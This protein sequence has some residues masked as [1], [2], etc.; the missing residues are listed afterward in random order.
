MFF[1][2]I[3]ILGEKKVNNFYFIYVDNLHIL[4]MINVFKK[5]PNQN[6]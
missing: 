6:Q 2:V 5:R 4:G 1:P 3:L